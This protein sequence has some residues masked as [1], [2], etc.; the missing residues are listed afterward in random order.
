MSEIVLVLLTIASSNHRVYYPL[1]IISRTFPHSIKT[2][3]SNHLENFY[4]II[5]RFE[6]GNFLSITILIIIFIIII[7]KPGYTA[8]IKLMK[9]MVCFSMKCCTSSYFPQKRHYVNK[10]ILYFILFISAEQNKTVK[11]TS[12]CFIYVIFSLILLKVKST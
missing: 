5:Y 2:M 9:D 7:N 11:Q 12:G 4:T 10:S 3:I 8:L 1:P 6:N